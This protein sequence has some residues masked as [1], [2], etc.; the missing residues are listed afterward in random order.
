MTIELAL[1]LIFMAHN[2]YYIQIDI[3]CC[4]SD[5][6]NWGLT[7][8]GIYLGALFFEISHVLLAVAIA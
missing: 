5:A 2:G 4:D 6:Q 1:A 3:S 8:G 7:K